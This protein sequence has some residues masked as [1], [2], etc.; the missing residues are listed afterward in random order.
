MRI[1]LL[2]FKPYLHYKTNISKTIIENI[3]QDNILKQILDTNS[4]NQSKIKNIFSKKP[5]II[6]GLGQH[7]RGKMLRLERIGKNSIKINPDQYQLVEKKPT[8]IE[9]NLKLKKKDF[10]WISYNAGN[11]T[12]NYEIYQIMRYIKNNKLKTRFAFIHIPKDYNL[13][14]AIKHIEYYIKNIQ[15]EKQIKINKF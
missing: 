5:D 1:L 4:F 9:V 8:K 14:N 11:F 15:T 7:P 10:S 12:C 2:G 6:L 3:K 13:K